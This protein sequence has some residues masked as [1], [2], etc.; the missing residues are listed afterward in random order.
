MRIKKDSILKVLF[1]NCSII[2]ENKHLSNRFLTITP[3]KDENSILNRT[4]SIKWTKSELKKQTKH[5]YAETQDVFDCEKLILELSKHINH[6]DFSSLTEFQKG[7]LMKKIS[8]NLN[9]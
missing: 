8:D 1:A 6:E 9:E 3:A 5:C 4:A 2:S 7:L